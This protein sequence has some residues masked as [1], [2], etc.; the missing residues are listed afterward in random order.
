MVLGF[1]FMFLFGLLGVYGVG[2][3]KQNKKGKLERK[4][5][6]CQII[7]GINNAFWGDMMF[8]SNV[9][10]DRLVSMDG[11]SEGWTGKPSN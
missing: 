8:L 3:V 1:F 2:G 9:D 5:M 7:L 11:N 10:N 4:I 6:L